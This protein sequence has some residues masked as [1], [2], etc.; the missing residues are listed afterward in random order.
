MG[1]LS[2]VGDMLSTS[3]TGSIS[4]T[5]INAANNVA[6]SSHWYSPAV[7]FSTSAFNWI[8]DNPEAA[9]ILGGVAAGV[10]AAYF[11][12]QQAA[13]DRAFKERMYERRRRDQMVNPGTIENYGSHIGIVKKGLL[14]NGQIA[15]GN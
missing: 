8:N 5:A 14:T 12:N 10:G 11:Q 2:S 7:N 6:S 4:S 9:N 15:G 13:D 1:L 3:D